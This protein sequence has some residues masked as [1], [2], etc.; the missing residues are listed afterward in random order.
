MDDTKNGG[1]KSS[2]TV[3][4]SDLIV[5]QGRS[6]G[7]NSETLA[8]RFGELLTLAESRFGPRDPSYVILGTEFHT[9]RHQ[10]RILK[11]RRQIVIQLSLYCAS[12]PQLAYYQ[13]AY[14]CVHV[15]SPSEP[16][17][18]TVLEES[19]ARLFSEKYFTLNHTSLS[20]ARERQGRAITKVLRSLLEKDPSC[21]R[22]LREVQ[23]SF[24]R[25]TIEELRSALPSIS[26]S[27]AEVLVSP[28]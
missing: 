9:G 11:E 17:R 21:I 18:L 20:S 10:L 1:P 12:Y 13:L 22:R 16:S 14:E 24:S 3:I 5:S 2:G 25:M 8:V 4:H 27:I 23:P 6:M 26:K 7:A 15:L 19:L 28:A